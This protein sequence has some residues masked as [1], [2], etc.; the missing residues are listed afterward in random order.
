MENNE[1]RGKLEIRGYDAAF[2][3]AKAIFEKYPKIIKTLVLFGSYSKGKE[4]E[5]SDV[6]IM[7]ILDDV[8]NV[9]DEKLL[10]AFYADVDIEVK[11]IPVKLHM[12]FVTLTAFWRGVMAADPVTVNVLKYGVPLIDTGYFEPLQA[13]LNKGEIKPTEE[14]IYA[15]LSRS[16]LYSGSARLKI[17]SAVTDAYWSLINSSQAFLMKQGEIPPS[18]EFIEE[19]LG[20]QLSKKLINQHDMEIF[21]EVYDLG[22]KLMHGEKVD[23]TGEKVDKILTET[24]SFNSKMAGLVNPPK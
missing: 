7:V 2:K 1:D 11:S 24:K 12:N 16:E 21:K 19:M 3:F 9:L 13:L 6:D 5:Q 4:N 15:A 18:P 17:A 10:A 14:S 20:K 23:L 22:K 8:L